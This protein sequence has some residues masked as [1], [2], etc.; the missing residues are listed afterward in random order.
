VLRDS[1]PFVRARAGSGPT[2]IDLD[3][4]HD[5]IGAI[6]RDAPVI[7]GIVVESLVDLRAAK[8]TCLL[9]RSE[10][11]DLVDLMFLDRAGYPPRCS[12]VA[13]CA[14]LVGLVQLGFSGWSVATELA[15]EARWPA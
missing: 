5:S 2:A 14:D 12:R 7:E 6:D 8:L 13:G 15:T 4:V 3:L 10:P 11:R 9:S 1:G